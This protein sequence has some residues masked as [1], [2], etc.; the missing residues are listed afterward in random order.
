MDPS[1]R[2]ITLAKV[3]GY[4][5]IAVADGDFSPDGA[6]QGADSAPGDTGEL[7]TLRDDVAIRLL[8]NQGEWPGARQMGAS[9]NNL[10]GMTATPRLFGMIVDQ[11]TV[12]LTRDLR[13]PPNDLDVQISQ[14]NATTISLK[15][16][17][18]VNGHQQKLVPDMVFDLQAG[19]QE[20]L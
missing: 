10:V 11:V 7:I 17:A 12:A 4:I 18:I 15:I 20:V 16:T 14:Q 2:D 3:R 5:D 19:L 6:N 13:I 8:T 9:I 1:L